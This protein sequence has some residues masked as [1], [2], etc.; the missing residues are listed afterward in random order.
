MS[1]LFRLWFTGILFLLV[2]CGY[3]LYSIIWVVRLMGTMKLKFFFFAGG[4]ILLFSMLGAYYFLFPIGPLEEEIQIVIPRNATLRSI[5]DTLE[6]KEI[7]TSDKVLLIWLKLSGKDRKIQAGRVTFKKGEGALRAAASLMNAEAIETVVTIQEG[8]TIEQTAARLRQFL[9]IDTT[10]F[11]NLCYNTDFIKHTGLDA[12][13]LEGYLFPDTYRFSDDVKPAEIIK[14][15]LNNFEQAYNSLSVELVIAGKFTKHQFVT[16]ASIVEKEATLPSERA[17][18]AGVFH[19]RLRLGY[20]LGAD[21]TV[22]YIFRK[23]N[24]P[25]RVSELNSNSPYNTRKFTGLPPGPICSPGKDALNAALNPE[26]TNELYFVAKWDGSG[27]HEFS[28]TNEEH[29]RKKIEIRR[30]NK[31]QRKNKETQ[32][33]KGSQKGR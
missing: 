18:I 12:T 26:K 29:D 20:P 13:S 25:L 23:F 27:A 19:N 31:L 2:I 15:M 24:G 8:L 3:V 28:L 33:E 14:R 17:R 32:W 1:R 11:I 6:K 22:R 10:E 4:I 30:R 16:L 21:P 9:P 7:V 5:A